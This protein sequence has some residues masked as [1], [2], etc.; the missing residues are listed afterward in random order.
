[1][2]TV[3]V[4]SLE[5]SDG[6]QTVLSIFVKGSLS[7]LSCLLW[8]KVLHSHNRMSMLLGLSFAPFL[9]SAS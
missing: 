8:V 6:M 9:N 1:M 7:H 4:L 3:L 5:R 2:G